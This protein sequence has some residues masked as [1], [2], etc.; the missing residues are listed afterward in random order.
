MPSKSSGAKNLSEDDFKHKEGMRTIMDAF[1][2]TTYYK[3]DPECGAFGTGVRPP[4][5]M[6][7]GGPG[8]GAYPIKTTMGKLMESHITSPCQFSLRGRT[9]F[10]DP[11]EKSMSK[12]AKN[13]PGPGQYDLTG[14]FIA[15]RD[16]RNIVFPKGKPFEAKLGQTPGPGSY[17]PVESMG[18][19]VQSDRL[20]DPIIGFAKAPR[21]DL[22]P[23]GTNDIG[24]GQY[25][26]PPA[27]CAPQ[28]ES[29][30]TTC[31]TIK[32][33]SGYVKNAKLKVPDLSEPSPGPG[34]YVIHGGINQSA[35]VCGVLS[36]NI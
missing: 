7:G 30:K 15:G 4:L 9:K 11:N 33:G 23:P 24:P 25:G 8:P 1:N 19:Q 18:K 31:A 16:P 22:V 6:P 10:G 26:R 21:G 27:A 5:Y 29:T 3:K 13:D 17:K 14:K 36:R 20:T 12:S 34:S 28:V 2:A 32:F 35:A